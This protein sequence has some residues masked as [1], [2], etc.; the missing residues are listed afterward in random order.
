M[1][2]ITHTSLSGTRHG[3]FTREGGVSEG[4]YA[5][6][7]CGPGSEDA[8]EKVAENRARCARS[9]GLEP[10]VLLTCYQIHSP[11]VLCVS[12]PFGAERPKADAMVTATPGLMLGILTADC[13]PVLFADTKAGV[14]GAAHAGWKGAVGGV[15]ENTVAAMEE[16]GATRENIRAI[17]GPCIQQ[18]SYEVGEEFRARFM[19]ADARWIEFFAPPLRGSRR[20]AG[21]PVGARACA[22]PT[23]S[24][25]LTLAG[26]RSPSRGEQKWQF[27]LPGFVLA[28]LLACG[29]KNPSSMPMDTVTD[30]ARFFSYRRKTLRGE[31]DYAR[32]LSAIALTEG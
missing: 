13:A 17:V 16:L 26:S 5:S 19:E 14:I 4:V 10:E 21:D 7:N 18:K 12:G 25:A 6:L 8:P 32:Q 31:M 22:P 1:Q 23:E 30:E 15:L 29:L 3:F 28:R 27:D 24:A 2:P 11:D 9:F 20:A